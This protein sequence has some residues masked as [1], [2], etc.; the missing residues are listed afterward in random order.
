MRLFSASLD[1][2]GPFGRSA[3]DLALAY[4]ALQGPDPEDPSAPAAPSSRRCRNCPR[5]WTV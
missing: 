4:D 1:A 2:G 3:E 5:G